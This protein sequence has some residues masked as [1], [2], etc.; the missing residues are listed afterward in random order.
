MPKYGIDQIQTLEGMTAIRTRPG[1]YIGSV[2]IDGVH[3][4]TLEIISN[5]IDEYLAGECNEI[6]V[7]V[8]NDDIITITDNGRGVPF[9]TKEDGSETLENIF[10]KLHT[11]AKFNS[12]GSSGYNS[13]GGM[14]GIGS[15]ATNALSEF[16]NVSSVRETKNAVMCFKEGR[17]IDYKVQPAKGSKRGTSIQF[18]PDKKIFKEGISLNKERLSNQLRE[19]SFLCPGLKIELKYKDAE[20]QIFQSIRGTTDYVEFLTKDKSNKITNIFSVES[21]EGRHSVSMSLCYTSDYSEKIKLY[22]NNIPNTAGTHLTGFRTAMT[23]AVNEVARDLKLLKDKDEN[24]SGEDLKEGLV[25][26]L[27]VKMPDPI[28]NGQTKDVLTSSEG[29]TIVEKLANKELKQWFSNNPNELKA[30]VS[31]AILAK[32]A[33]EA[34]KKARDL[35]RDKTKSVLSSKM[36]GKLTDCISKDSDITELFLVEGDSAGGGAK[37]ARDKQ[38]Q[39]VLPLQGKR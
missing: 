39:A 16:F 8:S 10:T 20:P 24:L 22:T 36:Q 30:I 23:R 27:S 28:F 37:A 11:G 14:N 13:S 17:R 9:G 34:A 19:L 32:K 15:K 31:K 7:L 38:F 25:L 1:M 18:K 12:D 6:E 29:R 26:V 4:I 21:I 35:T 3:Q 5:S 2:G 33:R